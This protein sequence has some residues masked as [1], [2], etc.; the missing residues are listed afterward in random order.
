ML[1]QN[2][3]SWS[4]PISALLL[5]M[6]CRGEPASSLAPAVAATPPGDPAPPPVVRRPE[7]VAS[8]S[9]A[10]VAPAPS[11]PASGATAPLAPGAADDPPL[12]GSD[13]KPLPQNE[14][15]PSVSSERFRRRMKQL[16][17]SIR[18]GDV[19]RGR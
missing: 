14:E 1:P 12:L 19:E 8:T 3:W 9:A 6:A 10:V 11:A 13:G 16:A 4:A 18:T 5:A 2:S 7:P 17:D 15:K